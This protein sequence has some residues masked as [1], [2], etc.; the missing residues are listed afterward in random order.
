MTQTSEMPPFL[1]GQLL[2]ALPGMGDPRFERAVI[3][4]CAHD[5]QGAL[6]IGIGATVANIGFHALL[7]QL[8]IDPGSA[9]DVPVHFGGPVEPQRGFILHSLDWGGEDSVQVDDKWS[10]T[11]TLD[12]L[13]AIAAGRGPSHW[14]AS[15]GYAGWS[16]GQLDE[17]MTRHG[18]FTAAGDKE[19]LF[20]TDAAD[21][22]AATYRRAGIDPALLAH[23]AGHA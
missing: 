17:E 21:R 11:G 8:E 4:M 9:P 10:L 13:R 18:W 23:D 19:I 20:E 22:W 15:L 2:L 7:D 5:E 16:P 3:A 6:G 1:S 14:L 12:I